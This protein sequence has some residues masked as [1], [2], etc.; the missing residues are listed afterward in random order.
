MV[1]I[2][3]HSSVFSFSGTFG[4]LFQ[5]KNMELNGE[6]EKELIICVR[7]VGKSES[8]DLCHHSA[9]LVM[10]NGDSWDGFSI[11]TSH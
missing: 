6:Q 10:P 2:M 9:S 4:S 11:P 1:I 5:N 8:W 3:S 7:P